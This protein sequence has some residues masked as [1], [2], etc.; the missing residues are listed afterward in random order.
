MNLL[1]TGGCGFI[2]S[3]FVN[4]I[5]K[6][7]PLYNIIN[8]DSLYYCANINNINEDV[9][10]SKNYK[11]IHGNI[12]SKEL[13]QYIL[14]DYNINY[15]VHF[16][17]QTHVQNSFEDSLTFTK[18]NVFGTHNLLECCRIYE[19]IE[20]FIY[21]STD[22]V[23]GETKQSVCEINKNEDSILCPTNPYAASKACAEMYV[24]AY[25]HSFN[26]PIIITRGN[27]VYGP[28]QYH[29]KVIPLFIKQLKENSKI[30]IQGDGS[31]IRSFLYIDDVVNAFEL[32]LFKGIKHNIYN[33]GGD[34]DME[35]SIYDI[36]KILIKLIKKTD[37]YT[38]WISF[39]PDRPF[40][41]KRY[42]ISNDKIKSLGWKITTKFEEGI[43][44]I[45]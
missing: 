35:Y 36:A 44:N 23:Y 15:V 40:N 39:I 42:Y 7:Y 11:F 33:I 20:K 41:D 26:M 34:D 29:E 1:I 17:A 6:K 12:C 16:A 37:N 28:N 32:I 8:I 9:R 24:S 25:I 30:T 13:I 21:V 38:E 27:N 31:C 43:L 14:N 19:K 45:L 5:V 18:D 2:G 22:E 4:H 10:E 3:N